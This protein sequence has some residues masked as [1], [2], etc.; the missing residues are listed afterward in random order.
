MNDGEE[1][2]EEGEELQEEVEEADQLGV[3]P[4]GVGGEDI[5]RE[6]SEAETNTE[7]DENHPDCAQLLKTLDS[8]WSPG[9]PGG[10]EGARRGEER[11]GEVQL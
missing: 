2:E 10:L 5:E 11:R 3:E 8:P 9:H 6:E 1:E 7:T 4:G